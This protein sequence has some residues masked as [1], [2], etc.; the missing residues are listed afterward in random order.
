MSNQEPTI[1]ISEA[2]YS[3]Q[4]EGVHSG[5]PSV[6][7]RKA[8]CNLSCGGWH[9]QDIE[10]Q[11]DM[12]AGDDAEW[13][14]DTIATWRD[15]DMGNY[16]VTELLDKF[17]EE[18]WYDKIRKEGA[19]LILT[20]GEPLMPNSQ[21]FFAEFVSE[22]NHGKGNNVFTEV[23][24]NGTIEPSDELKPEI[25]TYNV[26]LKLSNSGMSADRRLNKDAINFFANGDEN[27]LSIRSF[28]FVTTGKEAEIAEIKQIQDRYD[29]IDSIISLMP[30]GASQEELAETRQPVAEVCKEEGWNYTDRLQI[31][32]WDQ[33]TGV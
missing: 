26:S 1:G 4:G 27:G 31:A 21:E 33:A 20:G 9:N 12:Y 19:H 2:F 8:N 22:L 23:E 18:G 6:F 15:P 17:K 30:A 25:D 24:T 32:I 13:V 7:L 16:T 3:I 29:I 11:D 10:N 14:C 5:V 28:K